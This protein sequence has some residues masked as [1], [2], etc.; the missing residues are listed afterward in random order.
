[1]DPRRTPPVLIHDQRSPNGRES[2]HTTAREVLAQVPEPKP[3]TAER[4]REL[5]E[6]W[7]G[8]VQ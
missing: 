7:S 8:V 6:S 2:N 1:V 3:I 5:V 4:A